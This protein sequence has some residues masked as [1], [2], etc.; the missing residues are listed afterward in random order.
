[1]SFHETI[2]H[3]YY[4]SGNESMEELLIEWKE[5]MLNSMSPS[6]SSKW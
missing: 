3:T 2:A 4:F 1:M 6:I 5:E